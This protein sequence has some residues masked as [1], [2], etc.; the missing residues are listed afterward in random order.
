MHEEEWE[1]PIEQ[2][3]GDPPTEPD[4]PTELIK[5]GPPA[6]PLPDPGSDGGT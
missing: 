5:E 6:D 2:P 4:P 3:L 1:D